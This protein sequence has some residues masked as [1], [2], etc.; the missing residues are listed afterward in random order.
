M[1]GLSFKMI[2]LS[3]TAVM[4][5]ERMIAVSTRKVLAR[6][7]ENLQFDYDPTDFLK[8]VIIDVFTEQYKW[9]PETFLKDGAAVLIRDGM[10]ADEA[11]E[12]AQDTA[13]E[14]VSLVN[15]MC[16]GVDF[17][18]FTDVDGD[19]TD[20]YDLMLSLDAR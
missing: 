12:A 4:I 2:S 17:S 20:G 13:R 7:F 10:R 1:R 9:K 18:Q 6:D 3:G 14:I 15:Q 16:P 11:M 8:E 5:R 19:L